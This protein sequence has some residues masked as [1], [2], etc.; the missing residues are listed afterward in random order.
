[1]MEVPEMGMGETACR[2]QNSTTG[3]GIIEG[4]RKW[5]NKNNVRVRQEKLIQKNLSGLR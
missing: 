4:S 3:L 5:G 1:M 2:A